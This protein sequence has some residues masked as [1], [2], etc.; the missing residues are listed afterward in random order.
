MPGKKLDENFSYTS[1]LIKSPVF[2]MALKTG[3]EYEIGER[4]IIDV[5]TGLGFQNNIYKV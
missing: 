2:S 5:F 3:R 1:A 4:F